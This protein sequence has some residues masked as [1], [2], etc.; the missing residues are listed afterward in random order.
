MRELGMA[1]VN[2]FT[3]GGTHRN[4]DAR[5]QTVAPAALASAPV[6]GWR[7]LLLCYGFY[8]A[9]ARARGV[10]DGNPGEARRNAWKIVEWERSLG[11][12]HERSL[13]KLFMLSEPVVTLFNY[14][15]GMAHFLVTPAVAVWLVLRSP[16]TYRRWRNALAWTTG[17]ALIGYLAFPLMPPRL[18]W[19]LGFTDTMVTHPN[20]WALTLVPVWNVGNPYAAMPS[21]HMAWSL[22][23]AFVVL[24][25]TRRPLLRRLARAY[26]VVT[27]LAI[28]ITGNHFVLDAV[29]GAAVFWIAYQVVPWCTSLIDM[30]VRRP[31]LAPLA[32]EVVTTTSVRSRSGSDW[33]MEGVTRVG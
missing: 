25:H 7:E 19:G 29:G 18:M 16:G 22:W 2:I 33:G 1:I 30:P 20:P 26:P 8:F 28:V 32:E 9:Y 24:A 3:E 12:Y 5:P 31:A 27:L 23:V 13:Q 17:L 10:S 15:Y 4:L 14:F 6:R 11:M 21:L